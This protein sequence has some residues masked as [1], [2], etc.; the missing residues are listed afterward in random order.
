M[1]NPWGQ[2][3]MSVDLL[4]LWPVELTKS[5]IVPKNPLFSFFS[6]YKSIRAQI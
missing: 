5:V 3:L 2:I 1:N 4:S 6:P